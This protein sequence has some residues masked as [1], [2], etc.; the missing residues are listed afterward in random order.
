MWIYSDCNSHEYNLGTV[1]QK[2]RA[3]VDE[4]GRKVRGKLCNH[5]AGS[6]VQILPVPIHVLLLPKWINNPEASTEFAF[7][8]SVYS[9]VKDTAD[10]LYKRL[11]GSI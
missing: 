11:L 8:S 2:A 3:V 5:S 6:Q 7:S 4:G 10:A 9:T 1:A